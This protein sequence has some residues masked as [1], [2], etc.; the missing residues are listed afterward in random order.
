MDPLLKT[1]VELETLHELLDEID[2]YAILQIPPDAPQQDV[3][4]AFKAV[5]RRLHPD[6]LARLPDEDLKARANDI[7]RLA[8]E[9][10][11]A[12]KDP[13][14]RARYDLDRA[15]GR[16]RLTAEG[17]NEAAKDASS[18]GSLEAAAKTPQGEKYWKMALKCWTEGD[19]KG[20]VM[21]IR[22]ACQ[23]EPGNATFKEWL[24]KA[25]AASDEAA[26]KKDLNPYKLRIV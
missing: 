20:A 18:Q 3:D 14:T 21:H 25:T 6:R 16:L 10:Y 24:E 5:S 9:A 7:F 12:L 26:S 13:D 19:F 17:R 22:F 11:R 2:Y 8:N 1:R 15:E 23:Y 4:P